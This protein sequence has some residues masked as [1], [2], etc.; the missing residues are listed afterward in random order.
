MSQ[1]GKWDVKAVSTNLPR[2]LAPP[3]WTYFTSIGQD[4]LTQSMIQPST[5][6][7]QQFSSCKH[8]PPLVR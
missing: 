7:E 6:I 8:E 4:S 1:I 3:G 2:P 5:R